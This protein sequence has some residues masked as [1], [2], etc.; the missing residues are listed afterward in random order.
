MLK[1]VQHDRYEK[2]GL[3]TTFT[4]QDDMQG[5]QVL[6]N[7]LSHCER[8][9]FQ[10][11]QMRKLEIRERVKKA[12]FTLAEGATH[13]AMPPTI[14]RFF[15]SAQ[16]D[17]E[18]VHGLVTKFTPAFTLAEVLITLGI[19]GVV[20]A[21]TIPNLMAKI[22]EKRYQ[23]S[24]R[25]AYST[26]NQALKSMLDDGHVIDLK[27]NKGEVYQDDGPIGD[28]FKT[29]STYFAGVT[30]CFD[31][32]ADS[33]W[34]CNGQSGQV[35]ANTNNGKGCVKSRPAFIDA[36]GIAYYLY[37]G[38]EWPILVDVNGFSGPNELGKDRYVMYFTNS[39]SKSKYDDD[40]DTI[41]P[42]QDITVKQ[43]WCPSG[44]CPNTSR[45]FGN[46]GNSYNIDM[47]TGK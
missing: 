27:S 15:A 7:T 17:V 6:G 5:E 18:F 40:I 28:A 39:R 36:S 16:N 11:E 13:V 21:M 45:L 43:R 14:K 47:D 3:V 4:P 44:N 19:I 26:L 46:G 33:C 30:T 32:N 1:R 23:A 12:A 34:A 8:E 24:Y 9:E 10:L 31:K 22:S 38:S 29:L 41:Y 37:A 2:S 35:S 25:K 42:W 20:A